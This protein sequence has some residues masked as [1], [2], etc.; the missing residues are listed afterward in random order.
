M[1]SLGRYRASPSGKG[2][3]SRNYRFRVLSSVGRASPL[4][5]EGRG[6]KSLST[7]HTR[8]TIP[9]EDEREIDKPTHIGNHKNPRLETRV[10]YCLFEQ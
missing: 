7:H 4:Q 5:G 8:T 2:L 9:G 6:F 10:F 1:R 3:L